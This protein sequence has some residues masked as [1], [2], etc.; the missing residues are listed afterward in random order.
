MDIF[1]KSRPDTTEKLIQLLKIIRP[2]VAI[3]SDLDGA[4]TVV[5]FPDESYLWLWQPDDWDGETSL[6]GAIHVKFAS[7]DEFENSHARVKSTYPDLET[8]AIEDL[9]P[10]LTYTYHL[11]KVS[12]A[13]VTFEVCY[14]PPH[15]WP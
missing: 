14:E 8:T 12:L 11:Y 4:A 2:D 6:T 9:S 1:L 15:D 3:R 10:F 13:G 5:A 7:Q